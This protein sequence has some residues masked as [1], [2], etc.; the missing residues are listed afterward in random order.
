M[1]QPGLIQIGNSFFLKLETEAVKIDVG[2]LPDGLAHLVASYYIFN[3]S[4]P[5]ALKFVF[6]FFERVFDLSIEIRTIK[7]NMTISDFVTKV[8][9]HADNN[10]F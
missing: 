3:C 1:K 5:D 9:A 6:G 10:L 7:R 8:A 4:Y 2:G